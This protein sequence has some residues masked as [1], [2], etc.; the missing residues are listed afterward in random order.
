MAIKTPEQYRQSLNDGREVYFDGKKIKDLESEPVLKAGIELC[1]MDYEMHNKPEYQDLFIEKDE[2]GEPYSFVFKC[3]MTGE[4]LKRRREIIKLMS[5]TCLEAAGGAKFTGVDAL[6]SITATAKKMD[7]EL[8]TNYS[9]RV[10]NFRKHI[11]KDDSALVVAMTDVKGNRSLRPSKQEAH[12][13]YYVRIVEEREDGIVVR[14][15]KAH[16]SHSPFSNEIITLP[17]RAM[18]EDEKEYAV[19]FAVPPNAPG[20]K[21]ILAKHATAVN[22]KFEYP[23]T[24]SRYIGDAV[25]VFDDV[26][27][28]KERVFLQGEWQYAGQ[29]AYMFS[30]FHRLS[31]DSYKINELEILTGTAAL[32]AEYN[33]L[34]KVSHV[35]EKLSWLMYYAETAEAL[36]KVAVDHFETEPVSGMVYPNPMYSNCAKYFFADGHHHA[37]RLM[38]DIGGGILSTVP[39]AKEFYNPEI[40]EYME[41]YLSG[42]AGIPA[43]YRIRA[44]HLARD[45]SEATRPITTLHAE[46]SLY[47]QVLNFFT[48]GNWKHYKAAAK[49]AANIPDDNK[50]VFSS[51]PEF[52]AWRDEIDVNKGKK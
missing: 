15:A 2:D 1:A 35:R 23:I 45:V 36:G 13:D 22:D 19:A 9:E 33:G 52:G 41:K 17:C 14:G 27:I 20:L 43:E 50:T 28:P 7:K 26:F 32:L 24:G 38:Q 8:G 30:N 29:M 40:R 31:A 44:I 42:K 46:G 4:D 5:R 48:L 39:S 10:E 49:R 12:K 47:A 25:V 3:P 21:L 18:R 6:H 11:M 51:L 37:L 34:E 16:I